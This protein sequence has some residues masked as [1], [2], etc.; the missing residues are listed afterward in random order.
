ME[1]AF[2]APRRVLLVDTARRHYSSW[3]WSFLIPNSK[4]TSIEERDSA[5]YVGRWRF[6]FIVDAYLEHISWP[7]IEIFMI[8]QFFVPGFANGIASI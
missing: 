8:Q 3:L 2:L 5:V 1:G 7:P 4:L 6:C